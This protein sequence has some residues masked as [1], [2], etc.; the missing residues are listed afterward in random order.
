V[1]V[2]GHIVQH[3]EEKIEGGHFQMQE[4]GLHHVITVVVAV[5]IVS[6]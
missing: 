2:H 5:F 6:S 4:A 1:H 3:R